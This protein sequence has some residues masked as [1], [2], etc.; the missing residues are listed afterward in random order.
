V[1]QGW[2]SGWGGVVTLTHF[3]PQPVLILILAVPSGHS[4]QSLKCSKALDY[5]LQ[6]ALCKD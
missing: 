6:D 3:W 4:L 2:I 5:I 1:Q